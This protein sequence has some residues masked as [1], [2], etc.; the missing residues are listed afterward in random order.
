MPHNPKKLITWTLSSPT[1]IDI[2]KEQEGWD[3]K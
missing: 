3:E 1:Y 2:V